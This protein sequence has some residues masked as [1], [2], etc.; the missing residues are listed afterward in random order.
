[1]LRALILRNPTAL[2]KLLSRKSSDRTKIA[3]TIFNLHMGPKIRL[4]FG[5]P[6]PGKMWT[7]KRLHPF[8][9]AAMMFGV[10]S[11]PSDD[12]TYLDIGAMLEI[13]FDYVLPPLDGL[14]SVAADYRHHFFGNQ[15]G[16][17]ID[18]GTAGFS[19]IVNF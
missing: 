8:F 4:N 16:T 17:D 10:I 7:Y 14:F 2:T 15:T 6:E 3:T 11:P 19:I 18:Y 12:I 13:G 5:E 1:P 9:T